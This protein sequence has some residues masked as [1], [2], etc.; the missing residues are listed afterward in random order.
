MRVSGLGYAGESYMI[1]ILF[2]E[3][4]EATLNSHHK[5]ARLLR[6]DT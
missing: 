2:I 4:I 1:L 5:F 6:P 3:D